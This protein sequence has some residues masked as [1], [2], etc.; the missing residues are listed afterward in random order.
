[1]NIIL[2]APPKILFQHSVTEWIDAIGPNNVVL[3][4]ASAKE[5]L[6]RSFPEGLDIRFFQNF[7]DSPAVELAAIDIARSLKEPLCVALAEI[8][9]LRAARVNDYLGLSGNA[10][11]QLEM[12]RDKY[13]MKARAQEAGL[14]VSEMAVVRSAMD[15]RRFIDRLGF[16]VVL[17]PRDGRGSNGVCVIR[18]DA[19]LA[20]WLAAQDSST[21]YNTMIERFVAGDHYI[22][23]GLYVA[24]RPILI[25]PVRV[26]TSALDFL[27]GQSH[28][29]HMLEPATPLRDRLVAYSRRLVEEVMPSPPTLLF[30]LEV[31]VRPDGTIILGEIASRLGGVFFN[32]EM[33][34]A[35]GVD[36]RMTYLRAMQDP[37]FNRMPMPQMMTEPQRL[38]GQLCVPPREGVLQSV[39]ESCPFDFVRAYRM[40]GVAGRH[41]G[42]MAFT[43]AEILNAIVEGESEAELRARLRQ[44]EDWFHSACQWETSA[45]A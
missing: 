37:A 12:F 29:L 20:A 45:A 34:E 8:D 33:T 35:W 14:P 19:D 27:G 32:Q 13:A 10:A 22:V 40:S 41:Y 2:F 30:H 44:L 43:N 24:G 4:C 28:D 17:K 31:F 18:G 1:M 7:N 3:T 26:L 42:Q 6:M 9:V 11:V 16:P 39:P 38:V 25:S 23:N 21:F 36:P 5:A 15:I